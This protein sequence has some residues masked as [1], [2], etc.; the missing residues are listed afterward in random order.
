[1]AKVHLKCNENDNGLT[2]CGLYG[3]DFSL[4]T[5]NRKK[6]TCQT[7]LKKKTHYD[8][9]LEHVFFLPCGIS[10][11]GRITTDDWSKVTCKNCL[12]IKS[13]SIEE[14]ISRIWKEIEI[15]K[16]EKKK[17]DL[18][19]VNLHDSRIKLEKELV[20]QNKTIRSKL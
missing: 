10:F 16:M 3:V 20:K 18:R 19:I 9:P 11:L 13:K 8:P 1:M 7:C 12:K 2:A 6:A 5:N 4:M 17:I 14:A 15:A